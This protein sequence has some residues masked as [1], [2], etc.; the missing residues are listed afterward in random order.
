VLK[1][2]LQLFS[3]PSRMGRR[4]GLLSRGPGDYASGGP[5]QC[6]AGTAT[7]RRMPRRTQARRAVTTKGKMQ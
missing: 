4:F 6:R 2:Q 1:I 7:G 3:G 5:E